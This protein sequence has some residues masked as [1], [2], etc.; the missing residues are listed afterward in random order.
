MTQNIIFTRYL[1]LKDEVKISLLTSLI[2]KNEGSIFWAYELYYSGFENE[3]FDLLWKIYFNFYYT[4][5]PT[6]QQYFIKKHKEWKKMCE[7]GDR[8][9]DRI[10]SNIVN[11]LLIRPYNLDVF[12]LKQ[13]NGLIHIEKEKEK[14]N[15]EDLQTMLNMKKYARIAE[16]ILHQCAAEE[17]HNAFDIIVD[18]FIDKNIQL[19]KDKILKQLKNSVEFVENISIRV[20]ILSNVMLYYSIQS[21]LTMGKKLYIIVDPND[22]IMY[23]TI[24]ADKTVKASNILPIA[25]LYDIDENNYLSLF[26]L[27]RDNTN[28]R[29]RYNNHWEYYASFSPIWLNRIQKYNGNINHSTQKIDFIDDDQL[30]AFYDE[31]GYEPGEQKCETQNKCIKDIKDVRTWESFYE[32]HKKNGLYIPTFTVLPKDQRL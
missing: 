9:R 11:N 16:Y 22:I 14:E 31:F 27:E 26:Q 19:D 18:H 24:V 1:Y 15:N 13:Q 4:L 32:T 29:E 23:E 10:V 7:S 17:L 28:I 6:F 2:D 3:L 20:L 30:E 12:M 8:D 25:C 21:N 5:N